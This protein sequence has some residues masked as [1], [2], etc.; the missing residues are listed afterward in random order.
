MD[1][2]TRSTLPP[3]Q[4]DR[5]DEVSTRLMDGQAMRKILVAVVVL[6]LLAPVAG[7]VDMNVAPTPV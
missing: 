4:V 7:F 6:G 1:S 3:T 5:F 2:L